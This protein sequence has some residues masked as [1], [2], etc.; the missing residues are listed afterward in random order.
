MPRQRIPSLRNPLPLRRLPGQ[1][2]CL[3]QLAL[4]AHGHSGKALTLFNH[5]QGHVGADGHGLQLTAAPLLPPVLA[6]IHPFAVSPF[7]K[8]VI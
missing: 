7:V 1:Q 6:P 8:F 5:G 2:K 3:D 4:A